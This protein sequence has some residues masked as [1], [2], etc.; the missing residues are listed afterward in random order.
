MAAWPWSVQ[1]GKTVVRVLCLN[2]FK[3]QYR[4]N[5]S[6]VHLEVCSTKPFQCCFLV[7]CGG[8][9]FSASEDKYLYRFNL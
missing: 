3:N 6:S 7:S 5:K 4:T 8:L 9:C 1:N 2:G